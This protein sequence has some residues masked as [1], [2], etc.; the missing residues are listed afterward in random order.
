MNDD[1]LNKFRPL[2]VI[3]RGPDDFEQAARAFKALVQKEKVIAEYKERQQYEKPSI[4]KR[5]KSREATE[6]RLAYE[7]KMKL[8]QSGEWGKRMKKKQERR[9]Q[10]KNND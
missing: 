4:K 1:Y 9:Q 10:G 5:R 3:V 6:K 8:V 7:Y 2:Q